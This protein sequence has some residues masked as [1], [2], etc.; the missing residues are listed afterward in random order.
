MGFANGIYI[1]NAC[2]TPPLALG[3]RLIMPQPDTGC[4]EFDEPEEV[5]VV[6]LEARC[7]CPEMLKLS[8]EALDRISVAVEPRP[9]AWDVHPVRHGLDMGQGAPLRHLRTQGIAVVAPGGEQG[10][11]R[12]DRIEQVHRAAAVMRLALAQLERDK[13]AIGVHHGVDLGG[14]FAARAP[15]ASGC[16]ELPSAGCRRAPFLTLAACW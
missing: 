13:V 2:R 16:V 7:H 15:H 4:G 5:A 3:R 6:L 10:V 8:K 11:P 9:E 14:Q 12:L 1:S